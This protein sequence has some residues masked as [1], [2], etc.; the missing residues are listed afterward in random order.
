MG[1]SVKKTRLLSFIFHMILFSSIIN[2]A[3]IPAALTGNVDQ[4]FTCTGNIIAW[5]YFYGGSD[6]VA[7]NSVTGN[8]VYWLD[9]ANHGSVIDGSDTFIVHD[10]IFNWVFGFGG[11]DRFEIY[12]SNFSNAYADTN[13]NWV[14]Q[15]GNDTIYIENSVSNGWILG[16]NDSDMITIKDSRV[17]FIAAGYSDILSD[18]PGYIDYTPYDGN[19]T[20]ILDNVDFGE[21]NYY[22][23]TRPG[24][25]EGGKDDDLIVFKN[26]GSAYGVTAGHGSDRIVVEDDMLFNACTFTNDRGNPVACGIYGDEPYES[27][28][29]A[30]TIAQHGDDEIIINA[31]DLSGI[32][33]NGGHGSDVVSIAAPVQLLDTNLS[34]G[35]DRSIADGF[36][37]RLVFD[38]WIGDLN[39]SQLQNWETIVFDNV[40]E[41]TFLDDNL[42]VGYETGSDPVTDLPYG[43]VLQHDA[44]LNVSYDLKIDG[45]LYNRAVLDLQKDGNLPQTV[46][47]VENNYDGD[48]GRILLDTVLNDASTSVSDVLLVKGNTSGKTI[49][50][51]HNVNGSGG[52]TPTGNNEGILIV[53]VEGASNG[54]FSLEF[55]LRVG[56]YYYELVKGSNGNWYLQSHK[57]LPSKILSIPL[58]DAIN[59]LDSHLTV[60]SYSA[61]SGQ[62][63]GPGTDT[64][65]SG[66]FTYELFEDVKHGELTLDPVT[67]SYTYVPQ[68]DYYGADS[69][70][71]QLISDQ[72]SKE[73]NVATVTIL[74][75]CTTSQSSDNGGIFG[76]IYILMM[77]F[78]SLSIGAY[79]VHKD[80]RRNQ[81][82]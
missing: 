25:V 68:A 78:F 52:Q 59:A 30:T 61:H 11:D 13:P 33:V 42:T 28:P 14:D 65:C 81:W 77:L 12:D 38:G 67:G 32:V 63:P 36:V 69:F 53:E 2:A 8:T 54:E 27:E 1:M 66:P 4:N 58:E 79:F 44:S 17:S 22:Y 46:L 70:S 82:Q 50:S 49:L 19:D 20:I 31:G 15:R 24:A 40:S 34:G 80:E 72:C 62:L 26:G 39:G 43:L 71:Y 48:N 57:I 10:S 75:D 6:K 45:N 29:N 9:D 3:C 21:P 76:L 64:T 41:I 60:N 73:S 74:V 23:T 5:Q 37:D 35:D 56:D 16:G 7:L 55:D 18:I 47:S 51:I